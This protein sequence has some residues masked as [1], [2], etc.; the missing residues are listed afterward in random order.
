MRDRIF[1]LAS[2]RC[3]SRSGWCGVLSGSQYL[4]Q[5]ATVPEVWLPNCVQGKDHRRRYLVHVEAT[6][7]CV[8]SHKTVDA[9]PSAWYNFVT[10]ET[11]KRRR[12][13]GVRG[14]G[15]GE[16]LSNGQRRG[17][18]SP[19]GCCKPS[20]RPPPKVAWELRGRT[21]AD[22]GQASPGSPVIASA[23]V[24]GQRH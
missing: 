21:G 17:H 19:I 11:L 13:G 8:L 20:Q 4:S 23:L 10:T 15:P 14:I 1:S 16:P 12:T 22:A 2:P 6:Q 5:Y 18:R 24:G 3:Q 7:R 9:A